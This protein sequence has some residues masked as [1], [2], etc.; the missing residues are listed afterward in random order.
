MSI[1]EDRALFLRT[2]TINVQ[3]SILVHSSY[4]EIIIISCIFS[5]HDTAAK[6]N[7]LRELALSNYSEC[8]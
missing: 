2:S 1:P 7:R 6:H 8:R 5:G 4:S 3:L